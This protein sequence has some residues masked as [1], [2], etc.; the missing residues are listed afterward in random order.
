M[1]IIIIHNLEIYIFLLLLSKKI[2]SPFLIIKQRVL[3]LH[4]Q[5]G[6]RR[7]WLGGLD[8][9]NNS[10]KIMECYTWP[11]YIFTFILTHNFILIYIYLKKIRTKKLFIY[12][13]IYGWL[14]KV[15]KASKIQF[16]VVSLFLIGLWWY[17][18]L[19]P[20]DIAAFPKILEP[21][22]ILAGCLVIF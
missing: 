6:L 18:I 22:L 4:S 16:G 17:E 15:H 10:K 21:H 19:E 12:L 1:W 14:Q 7:G 2:I 9:L 3:G 8:P 13:F 11:Q 5:S 20:K